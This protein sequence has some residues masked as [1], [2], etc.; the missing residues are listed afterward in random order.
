MSVGGKAQ[1]SRREVWNF[2][3]IL[4]KK[5]EEKKKQLSIDERSLK[6]L[7]IQ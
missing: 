1:N 7:S 6:S 2:Y 5:F 3:K 4:I